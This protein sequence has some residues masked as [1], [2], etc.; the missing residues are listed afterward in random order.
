MHV[1]SPCVNDICAVCLQEEYPVSRHFHLC[2][3]FVFHSCRI[4]LS[5]DVLELFFQVVP[6]NIY[7]SQ[8]FCI[9]CVD[10]NHEWG[11]VNGHVATIGDRE[12][13]LNLTCC[14]EEVSVPCCFHVKVNVI[15]WL[16]GDAILYRNV[17]SCKME[18]CLIYAKPCT[19]E[20]ELHAAHAIAFMSYLYGSQRIL[21]RYQIYRFQFVKAVA[22]KCDGIET[23][24]AHHTHV[25]SQHGIFV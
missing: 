4:M 2:I 13:I 5:V 9:A 3:D 16:H 21:S 18:H 14:H 25:L 24:I 1:G 12:F 20:I 23:A 17:S 15:R 22:L 8:A 11:I 6:F 7:S 19:V 10:T